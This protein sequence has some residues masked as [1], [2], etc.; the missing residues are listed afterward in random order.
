VSESF[1]DDARAARYRAWM[2]THGCALSTAGK[3]VRYLRF[4]EG[5][6]GLTLD[7]K[8]LTQDNVLELL[9]L[10]REKGVLPKTLNS[11]VREINLWARYHSLGWKVAYFRRGD[12]PQIRVPDEELATRLLTLTWANRSVTARNQAILGILIQVGLRRNEIVHLELRDMVELETGPALMVRH[13]KGEK[14]RVVPIDPDL[15]A[16]IREYVE[17]HRSLTDATRVFTTPRGAVSYNYVGQLVKRAGARVGAP[18][19]SAHK[20]RHFAVDYALDHGMSVGSVAELMGHARW[21][22]T[23]LYRQRR[24]A[25]RQ[26]EREFRALRPLASQPRRKQMEPKSTSEQTS[27]TTSAPGPNPANLDREGMGARGFEPRYAG[28]SARSSHSSSGRRAPLRRPNLPGPHDEALTGARW[29]AKLA[30]APS[31]GPP[32]AGGR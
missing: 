30:Y 1:L 14:Q 10:H 11:W 24:L 23:Q 17:H 19:L 32:E 5:R 18:W 22:T 25:R 29:S 8:V 3:G 7:P 21:E 9:A 4:L 27:R 16:A 6:H 12:P 15:A 28:L 13:A 2:L 20:L 31:P 26:M